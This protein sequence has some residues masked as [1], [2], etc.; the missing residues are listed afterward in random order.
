MRTV[1]VV[2]R[3]R[4]PA[5][6][7]NLRIGGRHQD[8]RRR[9]ERGQLLIVF[10]LA[11]VTIIAF[12]G[13]LMD[14]GMA[15]VT[16][17]EAQ[18]AADTAAL[19]AAK[20]IATGGTGSVP[21]TA[22]DAIA[23]ANGFATAYTDCTG[24]ARTDG[25]TVNDPPSS[26]P[27]AGSAGYVEVITQRAMK[28]GFSAIVGQTCWMVSARA[29]AIASSNS[30]ATCNFCSLNNTSQN[31]TLVLKNSAA[32]RVDGDIYVDSTNGGTTDPCKLNQYNVCG[33]AFDI[34][35][36]G[37]S[38][39]AKTIA[40]V[41]GWETHDQNI[42]TADGLATGCGEHP[43]PPAQAPTA[44]VCVHMP[45]L[46]DP[47]DDP[48]QGGSVLNPPAFGAAPVAGANGCPVGATVPNGTSQTVI[49]SGNRTLCPGTYYGGLA[50]SGGTVTLDAG[51]YVM[52]GGGFQVTG[53][54][55]VNGSAGVLIYSSS[56]SGASCRSRWSGDRTSNRR[57]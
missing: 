11:L 49:T 33:D 37:G 20:S 30:V 46:V 8:V 4:N 17:R 38:I 1:P 41:G 25:V 15:Y 6:R 19:A 7:R 28:T 22:A 13:L 9:D 14:G 40:V 34:F 44:N 53:N 39:S 24:H 10:A 57:S 16:R 56:G 45:V 31:H 2:E 29:V 50:I 52:Q 48:N 54:A 18:N 26:G 21:A 32:L 51:T 36:A 27:N 23:A 42:A 43:Q 35:G 5:H 47:L 55:N 3:A 12:A